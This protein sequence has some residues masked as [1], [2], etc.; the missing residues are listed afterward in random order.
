MFH[1]WVRKIL[2][3]RKWQPTPVFLPGK[4]HGWRSHVIAYLG[5]A[6]SYIW[7]QCYNSVSC[8]EPH[9]ATC[10]GF[11]DSSV[12]K[13]TACSSGD[14]GSIPGLGRFPGGGHGNPLQYSCL[15]NPMDRGVC[16]AAAHGV[17]ELDTTERLTQ[18]STGGHKIDPTHLNLQIKNKSLHSIS[19]ESILQ[20]DSANFFLK[21]QIVSIIGF[22]GHMFSVT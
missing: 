3:R 6:K 20:Q 2:W 16:W 7:K 9:L 15:Q 22:M 4:S 8:V 10:L 1:P 19:T 12:G 14:L 13:E 5:Q 21:G 17:T 18:H 11:P